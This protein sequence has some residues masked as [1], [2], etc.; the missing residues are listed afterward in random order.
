[1]RYTKNETFGLGMEMNSIS[2]AISNSIINY[3]L[4]SR[5][6]PLDNADQ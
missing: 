6:A 2:I 1:M 5:G 4:H 3:N